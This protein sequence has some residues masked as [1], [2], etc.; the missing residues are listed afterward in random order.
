MINSARLNNNA[1][2]IKIL[3]TVSKQYVRAVNIGKY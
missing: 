2:E 1:L 3:G